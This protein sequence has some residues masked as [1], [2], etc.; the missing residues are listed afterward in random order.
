[1][2]TKKTSSK[3]LADVNLRYSVVRPGGND[4]CLIH[5]IIRDNQ[6]RKQINDLI[7]Q[8]HPNV[9]QVAFINNDP[10][11]AEILMA[12]GEFCGNATRS[13]A[14]SILEQNPNT[15]IEITASGLEPG[16]KLQAGIDSQNNA[17]SQMPIKPETKNIETINETTHLVHL[18]GI[19]HLVIHS[20]NL[21]NTEINPESLKQESMELIKAHKLETLP[22]AGVIYYL[23][24]DS[25][26]QIHPVV[27]VSSID[28]L[29]Y[30][31]GC[32]SGTTALAMVKAIQEDKSQSQLEVFQPSEM[33]IIV[34]IEFDGKQFLGAKISGPV[35][36]LT[37]GQ[38]V[39]VNGSY[40]TIDPIQTQSQ[41]EEYLQN[42]LIESYQE[43]FKDAPYFEHFTAQQ[44]QEIFEDYLQT[45][46][47]FVLQNNKK[48]VGFSAAV[49]LEHSPQVKDHVQ[50]HITQT[51]AWYMADLGVR[52]D[53]RGLCLSHHLVDI[54]IDHMPINTQIVMRT[55]INNHTS[56][57]IYKSRGFDY[58][59]QTLQEVSQVRQNQNT[60]ID[61]RLFMT[62]IKK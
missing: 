22:A 8:T 41:L 16:A 50:D 24:Q 58:L 4:T 61:T 59:D 40:Y 5:G 57:N 31:S 36:L 11:S 2:N 14:W 27:Y 37:T 52:K 17:W 42:G 62:K 20:P 26:I 35:E 3:F 12:G 38:L 51:Q 43:A 28:T 54:R 19:S 44:V 39:Q 60:E 32:G 48:V 13:A 46:I 18:D 21:A 53:H 29:F 56:Q 33:P 34:D 45:G 25:K 10:N 9:E 23:E 6:I 55:S 49:P 7:I 47:S 30:E 15:N 1:M